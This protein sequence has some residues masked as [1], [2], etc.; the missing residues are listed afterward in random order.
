MASTPSMQARSLW[1]AGWVALLIGAG[2]WSCG[3]G[4]PLVDRP[5]GSTAS[6]VS[7]PPQAAPGA[8]ADH[9]EDIAPEAATGFRSVDAVRSRA[10][11]VAAAHPDASRAGMAVL[12]AGGSAVD[13]A[14]AMAVTLSLVE[15]QSSGIG[16]GGFMLY[17][18]AA[19]RR[20]HGYDGRETAPAAATADQ[21]LDRDGQPL[22]FRRAVIGGLSV[23]VPGE[24]RMLEL[25]HR[26]HGKLP[27]RELFAPAIALAEGGFVVSPRLHQLLAQRPSLS[28]IA[29]ARDY[30]FRPDGS[31]KPV[32]TRLVNSAYAATLRAIAAA[33]ASA[34]YEGPIAEEV[35]ATVRGAPRN[36]GRL[37]AADLKG[38]RAV[39]R[40][41]VCLP[42]R[43][44]R[45]C[46]VPPPSGGTTVLQILGL[47]ERFEPGEAE[48]SAVSTLHLLCEASRLAYADRDWYLADPAFVDVP[49]EALLDPAY[50]ARRSRGIEPRRTMGQARP[51]RFEG[52]TVGRLAPDASLELPSTSHFVAVDEA[53]NAVSMT[54]SIESAFGSHLMVRGFLLNNELTDFS[55]VP[56]RHGKPVANRVE[57]GKRPRSSMSPVIVLD[58]E[59]E[60]F[61]LALGSPGG[62][63]IPAYVAQVLWSVLDFGRPLQEAISA[64]HVVNRN[65]RTEVEHYPPHPAW[66][67][68]TRSGLEAL[69]HRVI[70]RDL[71][72]GLH[73]IRRTA[74]GHL[75]GGA[76]P[77]REGLVL[78]DDRSTAP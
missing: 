57:P 12:E 64:P 62:S 52:P 37:T 5:V 7:S 58:G 23:G 33:G 41:P 36:P 18:D 53:G 42:H 20:L 35:V 13:A 77:R 27:W 65:G 75:V 9:K 34:F 63:R 14:V 71:N 55:F 1:T 68:R 38:Y 47:L 10:R 46:A 16:G 59:G 24:L 39:E 50:L 76:D 54:A 32:G 21:F 74:D 40:E 73:G 48:P 17:W 30:F 25:A 29:P 22:A 31:P 19:S 66:V 3:A 70:V 28:Q 26:A 43:G 56:S 44:V 8:G 45:I 15:P 6:A 72:S 2:A 51:G 49:L 69:G 67:R 61:V 60:R 4:G 11:M 78:G